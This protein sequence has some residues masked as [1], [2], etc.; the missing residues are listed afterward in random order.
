MLIVTKFLTVNETSFTPSSK[1]DTVG[2][3]VDNMI[4]KFRADGLDIFSFE[5]RMDEGEHG[6]S[7]F[8]AHEPYTQ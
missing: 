8:D 5:I 7:R 6:A 4:A 1:G 3:H 2:K